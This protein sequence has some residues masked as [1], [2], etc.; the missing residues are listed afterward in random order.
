MEKAISLDEFLSFEK[1]Y[2]ANFGNSLSGYKGAHLLGTINE[3]KQTNL[4]LFNSVVHLG[5]NPPYLGF[6]LRPTTVPRHTYQNIRSTSFF[7]INHVLVKHYET[8][9]QTSAKY[10]EAISEFAACGF[11]PQFTETHPAPYVQE[12]SIKIG[13]QLEEE[14]YIKANDTRFIVGKVVEVLVPEEHIGPKGHIHLSDAGSVAVVGLEEYYE[15]TYLKNMGYA[16]P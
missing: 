12:C 14:H 1:R 11:T 7:T 10:D 4:A 9:H 2:R 6:V 13:L 5:A 15:T 8:A 16:R 3:N